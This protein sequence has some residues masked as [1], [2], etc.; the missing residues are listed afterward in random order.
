MIMG[1]KQYDSAT[2]LITFS[3]ASGGT[4]LR[5]VSYGPELL[6]NSEFDDG[7]TGW[8]DASSAPSFWSVSGGV[9]TQ[10]TNGAAVARLRQSFTT[11]VGKVYKVNFVGTMVGFA[12]GTTAGNSDILPFAQRTDGSFVAV[13]TTAWF[14]T[15]NNT[16]GRTFESV[17]V[18]E[19]TFDQADGTLELF[20][21]PDDVPRI[22]YDATGA[23]KGLLIEEARTNLVTYSNDLTAAGWLKTNNSN[24]ANAGVAPDGT[25]N[26]NKVVPTT[27]SGVHYT[28]RTLNFSSTD[29]S[30]SVYVASAGYGF[31]T[32]CAGTTH[33]NDHYAVVIDLSDGTQTALYSAG[34][35]SKTVTVEPVGSFYRVTISGSGE[36]YYVVGASDTGT[37]TPSDYG[38]KSFQGDGT[39]GIL[40]YGAQAE[41]GAF[42]TSYI[43]TAGA[44]ATRS[45][46]VARIPTSAFGYNDEGGTV[47]CDFSMSFDGTNFPRVW[48]IGSTIN[49]QDRINLYGN[50][51]DKRIGCG[52]L[53]ANTSQAGFTLSTNNTVP[54]TQV[55]VAFSWKENDVAAVQDGGTVQQDTVATLKGGNPRTSVGLGYTTVSSSDIMNGHIK[56]IQYYPRRLTNA[57][58]QELTT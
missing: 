33:N 20:N 43:P 38:F 51:P 39:S 10:N 1:T 5:K 44:T 49:N 35:Q 53:T 36:K 21:H 13:G 37:Y 45:A 6:T 57:Q 46:D 32:I 56:S 41:A 26:A 47:V 22:E 40:V 18:K 58:L 15:A 2:D 54:T 42:P 27:S 7:L 34:A 3:R 9:A 50:A 55:K 25:S 23:V 24:T 12:I 19:V 8:T 31:A 17:S 29:H 11:V 30:F 14:G 28:Y 52:F 48:E 16:D 4:A